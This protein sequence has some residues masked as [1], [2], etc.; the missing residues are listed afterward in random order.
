MSA[1][2]IL[3]IAEQRRA[4][5]HCLRNH[6]FTPANT[7]KKANGTRY[8]LACNRE[9]MSRNWR[10]R[11][12]ERDGIVDE[13]ALE[14]TLQGDLAV[15]A[16]LTKKEHTTLVKRLADQRERGLR[17]SIHIKRLADAVGTEIQRREARRGVLD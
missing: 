17:P 10:R 4:Q 16:E 2:P 12:K 5:T 13:V 1:N 15:Y 6:E 9:R 3:T 11:Q 7:F 14:R 8:C